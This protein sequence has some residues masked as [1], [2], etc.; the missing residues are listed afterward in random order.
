MTSLAGSSLPHF[1]RLRKDYSID[2]RYIIRFLTSI[3]VSAIF[4]PFRWWEEARWKKQIKKTRLESPPVFIIGFWRSGTTMLHELLCQS[5]NA[6]YVTT[7]QTVFPNMLLSHYW[8][9]RS[10]INLLMPSKRPFDRMDMDLDY[11]QEEEIAMA[12]IQPLSFYNFFYFPRRFEKFYHRDLFFNAAT[13]KQI[14]RWKAEYI[15]LIRKAII[16]HPGK[17]FISKNPSNMARIKVL[18]EMFPDAKYIF[19]YRNPYKVIESFYRFFQEVL[20]SIQ[21]QSSDEDLTRSLITKL[22]GDMIR[23]YL[24]SRDHI[25]KENLME[26]CYEDVVADTVGSVKK[27]YDQFKL[28]GF[29]MDLPA[30]NT[31]LEK[32]RKLP[33]NHYE[34]SE[35]T[36]ELVNEHLIDLLEMWNYDVKD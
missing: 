28:E 4:E 1:I 14:K 18:M 36:I 11:P 32:P 6:T 27:I 25:P 20:P 24:V 34:I 10:L 33:R 7:Y 21:L 8:W 29:E 31:Y 35:R 30:I 13:D 15:K 23:E 17:V 22:Y 2:R 19:L 16:H 12:N 5:K 3:T 26:I 9:F